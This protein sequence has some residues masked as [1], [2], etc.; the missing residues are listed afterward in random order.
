MVIRDIQ[1]HNSMEINLGGYQIKSL[2]P[3]SGLS[4]NT[5]HISMCLLKVVIIFYMA[6][7]V[8]SRI[9]INRNAIQF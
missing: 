8:L 7:S 5:T 1:D 9:S 2:D 3:K 6:L 4:V